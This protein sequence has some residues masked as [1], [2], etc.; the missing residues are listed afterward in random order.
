MDLAA[1]L[2]AMA[3]GPAAEPPSRRMIVAGTVI[4]R[5]LAGEPSPSSS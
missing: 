3:C 4:S 5:S 1:A 2:D